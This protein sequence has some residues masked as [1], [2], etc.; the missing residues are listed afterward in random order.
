TLIIA[1]FLFTGG[2]VWTIGKEIN[3]LDKR[4]TKIETALK[5]L[6]DS[7]GGKTKELIDDALAAAQMQ[8]EFGNERASSGL[9]HSVE[10]II[11]EEKT[12]KVYAPPAFF[13]EAFKKLEELKAAPNPTVSQT[14]REGMI[15][16]ANYRSAI[17]PVP[18]EFQSKTPVTT[19]SA[20][21]MAVVRSEEHTSE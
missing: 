21:I 18:K 14:A 4:T 12:A 9:L 17:T 11:A 20:D 2:I 8:N 19:L 7:Q 13:S 6:A 16:L 1:L 5:L 3:G 15:A 10:Q